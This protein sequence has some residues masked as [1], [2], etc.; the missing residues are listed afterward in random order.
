MPIRYVCTSTCQSLWFQW[1]Q[2]FSRSISVSRSHKTTTILGLASQQAFGFYKEVKN[3][4]AYNQTK[5][6]FCGADTGP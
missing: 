2:T 1:I 3:Y 5:T 4:Q 6:G